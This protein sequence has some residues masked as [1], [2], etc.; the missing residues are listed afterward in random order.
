[1]V[2]PLPWRSPLVTQPWGLL[3]VRGLGPSSSAGV[4][5]GPAGSAGE[6]EGPLGRDLLR[7]EDLGQAQLAVCCL[8][9]ASGHVPVGAELSLTSPHSVNTYC[10]PGTLPGAGHTAVRKQGSLCP[11][12]PG[13]G[14]RPLTEDLLLIASSG[15]SPSSREG[16]HPR[17]EGRLL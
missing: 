12:Q 3:A 1:M 8:C 16:G 2:A 6:A 7:S 17:G 10:V 13:R 5:V 14:D 9:Q 15:R 11:S 4:G